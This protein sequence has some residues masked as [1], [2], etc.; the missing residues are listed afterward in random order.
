MKILAINC[1]S[2]SLKCDV[3]EADTNPIGLSR[4]A[5]G[6]V[7][8]IGKEAT[9]EI[10]IA[11]QEK[12]KKTTTIADH[13]HA[14][15]SIVEQF[16]GCGLLQEGTANFAV[17]HRIVHG[18][19]RFINPTLL[20]HAVL[21]DIEDLRKLA[22]LH[23]GPALESIYAMR[24]I[25]GEKIPMVGIFDTAFHSTLPPEA[26]EYAIPKDLAKK[27]EI[28]RYGFHGLAHRSMKDRYAALAKPNGEKAK[29]ITLQLGNGCSIAAIKNGESVDTSMGLSPLEGLM[30]GTRSGDVDPSLVAFL[31]D[32]EKLKVEEVV[33]LL[34][35]QSGL[36]GVSGRA[37]DMRG[38]LDLETHG[39]QG[40]TLAIQMFCYRVRKYIGAYFSV[41]E[42]AEAIIF[43]GGIGEN[44][45]IIRERICS[46]LGWCG[47]SLDSTL[48]NRLNGIEGRISKEDSPVHVYVFHADEN[49]LIARDTL[50]CVGIYD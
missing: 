40:A 11:G 24:E 42:G 32:K 28:K 17:G 2:S 22:P 34:N 8:N 20:T 14:T 31:A 47:V 6:S 27:H 1:G 37:S 4:A 30:M 26:R 25:F 46:G 39:D 50:S 38:L 7:S 12:S 3:F 48:N 9:I 21:K 49:E 23:N 36:L 41:L 5:S 13:Q 45:S 43:G 16:K 18:G 10:K 33:D 29:I 15:R 19:S 35:H 44:A